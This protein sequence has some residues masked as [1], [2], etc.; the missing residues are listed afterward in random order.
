M[1][2]RHSAV[3]ARIRPRHK[4]LRGQSRKLDLSVESQ[5]LRFS[6]GH[7]SAS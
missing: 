4:R 6:T 5:A 1:I 2:G 3:A 7:Y